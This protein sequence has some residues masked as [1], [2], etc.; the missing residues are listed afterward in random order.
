[1]TPYDICDHTGHP[2]TPGH[3]CPG[4]GTHHHKLPLITWTETLF[5]LTCTTIIATA[6]ILS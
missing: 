5:A 2:Y 4:C 6:L 3:R 1:M